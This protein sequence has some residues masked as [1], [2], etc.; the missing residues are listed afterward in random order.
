MW[1]TQTIHICLTFAN[2]ERNWSAACKNRYDTST[3]KQLL[4]MW[5]LFPS[6]LFYF[7]CWFG[8]WLLTKFLRVECHQKSF[9][10]C[11]TAQLQQ[12]DAF[13]PNPNKRGK[14]WRNVHQ[15]VKVKTNVIK[16]KKKQTK[17]LNKWMNEWMKKWMNE[18]ERKFNCSAK[19]E[20]RV[21]DELRFL[22]THERNLK[23][24]QCLRVKLKWNT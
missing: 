21:I 23:H 8:A 4:I 20:C 17:P 18:L 3:H 5:D 22:E 11:G 15:L 9:S 24:H 16:R 13:L 19:R 14:K 1:K 6:K 10:S 12:E 7:L 2:K